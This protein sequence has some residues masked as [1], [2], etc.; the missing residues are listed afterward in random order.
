M[1]K[2]KTIV[3][4][5]SKKSKHHRRHGFTLPIAVV[6][7]FMPLGLRVWSKQGSGIQAMGN[8]VTKNVLGYD[9]TTGTFDFS[10]LKFGTLPIILGILI[11]KFVG[12]SLG[13]NRMLASAR[14]PFLRL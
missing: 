5:R 6:T 2:T 1:A 7:G 13:V 11:H 10:M 9:W 4:Y 14:V 3:K 8:E 12:G